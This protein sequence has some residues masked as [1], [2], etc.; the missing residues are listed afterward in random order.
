[1]SR[2]PV[3]DVVTRIQVTWIRWQ[4]ELCGVKQQPEVCNMNSELSMLSREVV[5]G[6]RST[7]E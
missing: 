4:D 1:M 3:V 6:Q 7:R 5:E 2:E